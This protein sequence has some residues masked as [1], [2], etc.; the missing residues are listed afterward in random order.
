[1][2]SFV[3]HKNTKEKFVDS[4]FEFHKLQKNYAI[5]QKKTLAKTDFNEKCSAI[6]KTQEKWVLRSK[7]RSK[8]L[9]LKEPFL[10]ITFKIEK[11]AF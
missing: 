3:R 5:L 10:K 8:I 11:K 2:K 7:N 9:Y 1:M 4:F 6:Q